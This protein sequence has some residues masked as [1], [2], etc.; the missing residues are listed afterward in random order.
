MYEV[1]L[2]GDKVYLMD[3]PG[4]DDTRYSD[5]DIMFMISQRLTELSRD[6]YL[7]GLL[8]FQDISQTRIGGSG[9]RVSP[10]SSRK[11]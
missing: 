7:R 3:T 8:Y 10:L 2:N 4:F 5:S 6:K 11:K 1:S 9:L